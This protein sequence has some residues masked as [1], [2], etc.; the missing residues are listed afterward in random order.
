[1]ADDN[2]PVKYMRYAIGEIVLV[3]IG[4]LIAL[5]INNWNE[6]R[7]QKQEL[8]GLLQSIAGGVQSDIRDLNLLA[9]ARSNMG[10]KGDSIFSYY[11]LDDVK[12]ISLEETAYIN[13]AFQNVLNFVYFKSNLSAFES[14]KNSTYFGKLQGTDLALLLSAYYT[15]ADKIKSIEEKYNESLGAYHAAWLAKFRDNGQDI[16]LRP[17][18]FYDDLSSFTPRFREILRDNSTKNIFGHAYYEPNIIQTYEEQILMGNKLIEMI[19]SSNTTFDEQTKLDF[20]GILYSFADA[21][22][23]SILINGEIPTGFEPKYAASV[24]YRDHFS[25]KEDYF[26]IE[27]PENTYDWGS[28]YFEINALGGRVNEMDFSNYTKIFIEMKGEIGGEQFEITMKDKHD[29]PDGSESRVQIELTD[30]WKIYEIQTNQF[31]TAD[32]QLIMVP[33]GFVFEGPLGRTIHVRSIQFKKD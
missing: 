23:I 14:L 22:L 28:P 33:L 1:M 32:M 24:I 27:Y 15:T 19:K 21:D 3:V 29:P 30:Q 17:W 18:L 2:R 6:E 5:Q 4:I 7:I 13:T 8:E 10:K 16:F 12:A 20:S 11:I 25:Y 31:K 26:V 9:T